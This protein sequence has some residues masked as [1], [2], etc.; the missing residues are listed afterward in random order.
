M[1]SPD[2]NPVESLKPETATGW[3]AG[4]DQRFGDWRASVTYFERRTANQIDFFDCWGVTSTACSARAVQGGYY[5]NVDRSRAKGVEI[6]LAG[7]ITDR[8]ALAVNYT[9]LTD[10]YRANGLQRARRPHDS[11]N[12]SLT[13]QVLEDLNL[14]LSVDY[15]GSRFDDAGHT[16]P[17]GDSG[18]L[19]L[20]AATTVGHG[21][22]LFGRIENLSDNKREPVAGYGAPGRALFGGI[23]TKI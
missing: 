23:R 3:E 13:W 15:I 4:L 14:G 2:S 5:Y 8:L 9:N 16:A 21:V 6:E 19:N 7:Q 18:H 11:A 20:F 22:E 10:A 1:F 12:A 17:L